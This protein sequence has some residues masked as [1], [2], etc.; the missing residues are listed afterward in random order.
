MVTPRRQQPALVWF[1]IHAHFILLLLFVVASALQPQAVDA[2]SSS[3][4]NKAE[5]E[6]SQQSCA[7]AAVDHN[8]DPNR[9]CQNKAGAAAGTAAESVAAKAQTTS[10]AILE[11][12]LYLAESTLPHAGL[13]IF[14]GK[15][16]SPGEVIGNGELCLPYY[17]IYWYVPML[18]DL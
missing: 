3:N 9:Q 1:L 12:G 7:A 8:N 6:Q 10:P 13:G 11:C 17:D 2:T 5:E 15:E 16:Y 14:A 4:N 18:N